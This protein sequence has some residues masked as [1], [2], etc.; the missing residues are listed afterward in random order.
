M[1]TIKGISLIIR[2]CLP[3]LSSSIDV[4]DLIC[5]IPLPVL[6]ASYIPAF[7]SIVPPVGKSG[8]EMSLIKSSIDIFGFFIKLIHPFKT[9]FKLC[10]GIFVAIPTAIPED[11]FTSKFGIFVGNTSGMCSLPS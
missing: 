5:I 8:P 11:P 6:Y 7:P 3:D 4:L 2:L 10:G 9:S 1:L